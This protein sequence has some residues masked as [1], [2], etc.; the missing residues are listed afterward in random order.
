MHIEINQWTTIESLATA[1]FIYVNM[2]F[3]K[4]EMDKL[5]NKW[6]QILTRSKENNK[7]RS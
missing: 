7:T 2:T 1:Q 4:W 5:F 3:D 6:C